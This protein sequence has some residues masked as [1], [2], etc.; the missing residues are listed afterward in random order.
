MFDCKMSLMG[1]KLDEMLLI[2]HLSHPTP[3]SPIDSRKRMPPYW[4]HIINRA[5]CLKHHH[6]ETISLAFSPVSHSYLPK[7]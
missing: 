6:N 1:L 5:Q 2:A 7:G 3:A 4:Y